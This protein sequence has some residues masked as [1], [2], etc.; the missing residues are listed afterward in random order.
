M[1]ELIFYHI[2]KCGGSSLRKILFEYFVKIYEKNKIFIPEY[3]GDISV[4]Y[5]PKHIEKIKQNPKFDFL[6]IKIILSHIRFNSFPHLSKLTKFKFT[7]VREPI[8]RVISHYYFFEFLRNKIE[9]IDLND[10]DFEKFSL[11]K[12]NLLSFC[13]DINDKLLYVE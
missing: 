4:N 3:S 10:N 12:G 1:S 5:L 2:E 6:N 8:S 7:C 13:L 11:A 9:F